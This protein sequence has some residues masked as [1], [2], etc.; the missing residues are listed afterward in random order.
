[1]NNR[2]SVFGGTV[3][4]FAALLLVLFILLPTFPAISI[5][6]GAAEA[7]VADTSANVT[8]GDGTWISGKLIY[9]YSV[10][11]GSDNTSG[12][13]GSVSASSNTLTVKA[14]SAKQYDTGGCNSTTVAAAATTTTVTVTNT[15]SYPLKFNSLSTTGS[16]SVAGVSQGDTIASDATFTITVTSPANGTNNTEKTG[17]VTVSV[18]EETSVTIT[19]KPSPYIGYTVN[20]KT[21]AQNGSEQSFTVDAGTSVSLPSISAPSGYKFAGWRVGSNLITGSSFTADAGY[22][23]FPVIVAE[24]TDTTSANFKVGSTTYTFW[25]DAVKAAAGSDGK[26]FVNVETVTLPD[27]VLD[28]TL[29][30]SGGTYVKP[31]TGGGVEYIL[32]SSVT[33]VVPYSTSTTVHTTTPAYSYA[34]RVNPSPFRTMTVPN[35]AKLT[36]N[37]SVSVD[38]AVSAYGQNGTSANGTPTGPHGKIVMKSGS[39]MTLNSGANLYCYGYINGDG[40]IY[41]KSGAKVYELFQFRD[42]RGGSATS[43]IAG[44]DYRIFPMN[45]YYV[46]N[47]E[48]PMTLYKGATEYVWS[49]VNMSSSAYPTKQIEFIGTNGMF[50]LTGNSTDY[51]TKRYHANVDRLEITAHG[52]MSL[53]AL[54]VTVTGLPFIGTIDMQSSQYV[55]P[56][57]NMEIV[58][59]TG[60][61]SIASSQT[62]GVAFLPGSQL[63]VNQGATFT[64]NAPVYF[65]DEEDW[66]AYAADSLR[67]VAVGYSTANGTSAIRTADNLIDAEMDVN[68]TV[69][70]SNKL[71]TTEH[72]AYITSSIGTGVINFTAD[73]ATGTDTTYQYTQSGTSCTEHDITVNNAWLQNGDESYS[74][75]VSTG[76]STWKYDKPGEHWYRYLVDFKFNNN[77]VATGYYCENNDTVTYDA[78]WLANLGATASNGTAAISGTDVIVTGVTA[79]ST[80]TLTGTPAEYIPTFVLSER[81]YEHYRMYNE[82]TL[83][84]TTTINGET[85]Y[86]VD[87]AGSALAVGTAYTAPTDA[88]MGVSAENHNDFLWNLSGLSFTSG[89]PYRGVVPAGAAAGGPVDIYGFYEGVIAH[90]SWNDQYYPTLIEAFEVL[91]QDVSATITLLADCGT[92]EDESGTVAYTAYAANNIKLDLNGHRAIGRIVNNGT[93]TLDLN[94]GTFDYHTGATTK[95][96]AYKGMAAVTNS[97]TMIIRDTVGGGKVTGDALSTASGADGSNVIRNNAG[98]TL[99]VTGKDRDHLLTIKQANEH[100]E[101]YN[102]SYGYYAYN[103]GI[104]N[105]GKITALTYTDICSTQSRTNSV[106]IYNYDTGVIDLISDSHM[107]SG[108]SAS[109]FNYGGTVTMV[110]GVTIDGKTGITNRNY[111][112]GAIA[113]GYTVTDENKG[114]INEIENCHIEVGQYAINNNATINTM[115]DSTFIAHPDSAQADTRGN[116]STASEG[117]TACYTVYNSGNWWYDT[118]VWKQVDSSSGGYTRVNYYQEDEQ[119]RPS[120]G[121]ITDCEIYAENTS[122]SASNGYALT[123]YGVINKISGTTNVKAYKHPDNAIISTSHYSLVNAGGGIIKSIEGTVNVDATAAYAVTNDSPF[124]TQINYTYGNKVGGNITYQ[125]NTYGQPA[126]INSITCA[127]TWSVGSYYA[128]LNQGYIQTINAPSLTLKGN[129]NVLYN[130]TGGSN[131]TYEITKKYTDAATASTEYER[132]TRYVKNLEK[133]ST[134]GTINGITITG[135]GSKSYYVL[136]NQGHIGTLSNTTVNFASGATANTSYYVAALNG[137]S[138][139][140]EYTETILTNRTAETDPKLTV[141]AGKATRYDRDYTYDTPTIDT[142]DNLT[143]N[144]I[145]AYAMRNAGHIGTLK[146]ST[147]TGTQYAL[148]NY[149]SG[150]YSERQTTQ[151]YSGSG[152]FATSKYTSEYSKHYKRNP[153]TITTIDNCTITTPANT[154]AMFNTGNVGTIKNS[155]LQAGTT[156]AKA[157]ALYN[158][159]ASTIV[160]TEREY[161]CNLEDYFYV[162]ANSTTACTAYWGSGGESKIVTYDYDQPVID[163]IGEGNTFKATSTVIANTG[164]ITAIDSGSGTKTTV[165]GSSAKGSTIYNYSACLDSRTTTTPYTAASAASTSGTAG[166]A[167]NSDTLFSGAQIG[168]IKN[169][170]INA[171]GYGILNGLL[172]ET[173]ISKTLL[174][175]ISEIGEG[176][177]IYAHCSTE[178]YHAIANAN[179]A[180]ITEIS[181]GTY[182]VTKA[183]TNAYRNGYNNAET[184]TLISGGNF[185]GMAATRA[186]AIYKPDDTNRVVYPAGKKLSTNSH[187]VTFNNGTTTASGSGYYYITSTSTCTVTFN[188]QEHGTAPAAQTIESGQKATA[189]SGYVSGTTTVTESDGKYRFDGWYDDSE[190]TTEFDFNTAITA[191][192]TVYAKWTEVYTVTFNDENGTALQTGLVDKGDTPSCDAPTKESTAQYNYTFAGWKSS[193]DDAVYITLPAATADVTYTATY[194]SET[195]GY[196]VV[197]KNGDTVLET[198]E[199]VPYLTPPT[200]DGA[201]PTKEATAQYSYTFSGWTPIVSP[202][203]GNASYTAV[204]TE[205]TRTYTVIWKNGNTTLETDENVPYGTTPTYDGTEPTKVG[206]AQYSYTFSGWSPSVSSVTGNATYTAQFTQSVNKYTVKWVVE[207]GSAPTEEQIKSTVDDIITNHAASIYGAAQAEGGEAWMF[208][209][210]VQNVEYYLLD[211]YFGGGSTPETLYIANKIVAIQENDAS[212]A[213]TAES[214]WND[215]KDTIVEKLLSSHDLLTESETADLNALNTGSSVTVL[216]T[217]QVDYGKTPSYTGETPTKEGDAQYSYTFSGW[218]PEIVPVTGDATY[219]AQFTQSVN[220]YTIKWAVEGDSMPTEEQ[221]K[222]TVD[223]VIADAA[224]SIYNDARTE[225]DM[226]WDLG[227]F[228]HEELVKMHLDAGHVGSQESAA[229]IAKRIIEIVEN[230]SAD[231]SAADALWDSCKDTIVADFAAFSGYTN[232]DTGVTYSGLTAEQKE[233]LEALSGPALTVLKTEQVEYGTT[234]SYTGDTPTKE[235]DAQYSYTFSGWSPEIVPVT[236]NATY[237]AQFTSTVNKYDITWVDGNGDTLKTEQV[238]YGET[239]SYTGDTPTKTATAQYTYTFNNSWSPE[240]VAVT[241]AATYTAQFTETTRSYTVTWKNGEDVLKTETLEYGQTPTAPADPTKEKDADYSY[242]FAGWSTDGESVLS[243]IP[244]VTDNATYVAVFSKKSLALQHSLTLDGEIGVNFYI[245]TDCVD[246]KTN[247]TVKLFWGP[248]DDDNPNHGEAT[249]NINAL[250]D[251][252]NNGLNVVFHANNDEGLNTHNPIAKA[253]INGEF[254]QFTAFVAAKQM[255]DEVTLQIKN[256]NTPVKTDTY[257]VADYCSEVIENTGGKIYDKMHAKDPEHMNETKFKNLQELC[258]AML[259]YGAK[260]QDQ[261][262]YNNNED[263]YADKDLKDYSYKYSCSAEQFASYYTSDYASGAGEMAYYGSSMQLEAETT[264]TVWL[265]YTNAGYEPPEATATV[266]G[267]SVTVEKM[268]VEGDYDAYYVRYNILNLPANLLTQDITVSYNGVK[269]T[270]NAKT[271]F[272]VALYTG[273][274]TLKETVKSLYNYN[275]AAVAYFG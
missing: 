72:G 83:D 101:T 121:E 17:T 179:Y 48:A 203:T 120:I 222:E 199:N 46:Q 80:V 209:P 252:N 6:F 216:K 64:V 200:Y 248:E 257:R 258:K 20:N 266:G 67:M 12:A 188:M 76:T 119:Y 194:N 177:E 255:A 63:T 193:V 182:T 78:S 263:N 86:I 275:Q 29:P 9:E 87:Q 244:T 25:E 163:L 147:I 208:L 79:D 66:G 186:N 172:T 68:G 183:T 14:T 100:E 126:T 256:G 265:R 102:S 92:Y 115:K 272:Y 81:E 253:K 19:L 34:A 187:N 157:Y 229:Y 205:T 167:V 218:S 71:Y 176:T 143:V 223:A 40:N 226:A 35:G 1:M 137:D 159:G 148:H 44:N 227:W 169:V 207:S 124:T 170:Y 158:G 94:G 165:T 105:R 166:T 238:E 156:T 127:G 215:A 262:S 125:K 273:N 162:T 249:F 117:N 31:V 18:S 130:S 221:I 23:V 174:P 103:Y 261:F 10:A 109:I 235:G 233:T 240:V 214:K 104:Y 161:T 24:G 181:G 171:N 245:P 212:V 269:K 160:G 90:N 55:L 197:W 8:S 61:T 196:T 242:T 204:F 139:Y 201:T 15:S 97:G 16:A 57:N 132:D 146:N 42:W 145:T 106:N 54:N 155:T 111:R 246:D 128:L 184:A 168:T 136:N 198:D 28:N 96:A 33:L 210:H 4:R 122:T 141:S 77:I 211:N 152:I 30:A 56:L 73:C 60:T 241:C 45:Q 234:P 153:A 236:G 237:T 7:D 267:Q 202:V 175:T 185:K 274:D 131:S 134:I 118:N 259:T 5:D 43:D 32:P 62:Y 93:F 251:N 59:E 49:V 149:A 82:G 74:K 75:T 21:V 206:D 51:I 47:V 154:Y 151:Y 112:T 173:D 3:K 36:V 264:Y 192:T 85:Y 107:F 98:A 84:Q 271:Y 37:G 133:G 232:A 129:Y 41:V 27:N 243:S 144:S 135:K 270:Y 99:T 250:T 140:A 114:I 220:K 91:P 180:K 65:Y 260:A 164:K 88:A 213:A 254:Y 69:N 70:V 26:V 113:S 39:E 108:G 53:N 138:R 142:I 116:G 50:K 11:T 38:S 228:T 224:Q 217:E 58:I 191:D 150:P 239:P 110:D 268:P 231:F 189:P 123:N 247:S 195:R 52:D 22:D 89:D 13:T 95:A 230:H 2:N 190:C 178:L 219:A 225:G